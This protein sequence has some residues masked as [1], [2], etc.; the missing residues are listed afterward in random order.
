MLT[1]HLAEYPVKNAKHWVLVSE[2]TGCNCGVQ[3]DISYPTA[4]PE[5][6]SLSVNELVE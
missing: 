6:A 1:H 2:L 3:V 4:H 5:L